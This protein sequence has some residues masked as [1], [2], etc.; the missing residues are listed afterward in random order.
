MKTAVTIQ[1]L[2]ITHQLGYCH[3]EQWSY[4]ENLKK[5]TTKNAKQTLKCEDM[6]ALL[7]DKLI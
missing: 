6:Y 7:F 3:F 5:E 4:W 2:Y 1:F